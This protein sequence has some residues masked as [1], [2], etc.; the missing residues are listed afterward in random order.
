LGLFPLKTQPSKEHLSVAGGDGYLWC[1]PLLA[2]SGSLDKQAFTR[3]I[4]LLAQLSAAG[5]LLIVRAAFYRSPDDTN[6][7]DM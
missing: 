7:V 6:V 5:L 2:G 1:Y 3:S 4:G